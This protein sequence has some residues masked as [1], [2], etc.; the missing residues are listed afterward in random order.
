MLHLNIIYCHYF[1]INY[2]VLVI[3]DI[4]FIQHFKLIIIIVLQSGSVWQE[5]G[6]CTNCMCISG[7]AKCTAQVCEVESCTEGFVLY[8][9]PGAC[10]PECVPS[11]ITCQNGDYKVM[12][13]KYF[14]SLLFSDIS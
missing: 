2:V 10:C 14:M 13:F 5:G 6:G 1:N 4:N 7:Q 8:T 9:A 12:K 3:C 11:D